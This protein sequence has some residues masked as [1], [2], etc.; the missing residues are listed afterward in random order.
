MRAILGEYAGAVMLVA[1]AYADLAGLGSARV[2]PEDRLDQRW[3]ELAA[4]AEQAELRIMT[5][6]VYRLRPE[7]KLTVLILGLVLSFLAGCLVGHFL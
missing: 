2:T 4:L 5:P 3:R 1:P 7:A 6:P